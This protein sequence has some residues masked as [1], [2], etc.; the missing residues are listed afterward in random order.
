MGNDAFLLW[1]AMV[2][3]QPSIHSGIASKIRYTSYSYLLIQAKYYNLLVLLRYRSEIAALA[4]LDDA[5]PVKKQRFVTCYHLARKETITPCLLRVGWQAAILYPYNPS[6][7]LNSS[8]V[9]GSKPRQIT[10]PQRQEAPSIFSAPRALN[11]CTE[12][13]NQFAKNRTRNRHHIK[14]YTRLATQL[15]ISTQNRLLYNTSMLNSSP[16]FKD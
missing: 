15:T 8:Q 14:L 6:K 11:I 10:P 9:Q 12:L 1:I 4:S 7:G 13:L 2:A 5:S 16:K 3:I